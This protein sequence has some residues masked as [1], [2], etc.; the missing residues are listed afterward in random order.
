MIGHHF[1]ASALTNALSASGV[2]C[3]G[4]KIS[5]PRSASRDRTARSASAS[6]AAAL[7]LPMMSFGVPLGA[8]SPYQGDHETAGS[9]SSAKVGISGA[10]VRRVL[11][12][13]A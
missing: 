11:L 7:S 9:P 8:K 5:W 2:C 4:G 3:S 13:A 10:T 6:A 12:V 1:S